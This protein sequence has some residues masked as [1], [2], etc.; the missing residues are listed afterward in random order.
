MILQPWDAAPVRACLHCKHG[1]AGHCYHP[2]RRG[3]PVKV[4]DMRALTGPCGPE[5]T[6]MEFHDA[7]AQPAPD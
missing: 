5:A 1:D 6:L 4:E 3:V 2:S 7:P